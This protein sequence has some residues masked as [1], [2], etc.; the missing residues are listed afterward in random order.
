MKRLIISLAMLLIVGSKLFSQDLLKLTVKIKSPSAFSYSYDNKYLAVS[1]NSDVHLLNAGSDTKAT[2]ISDADDVSNIIFSTDN[3][4]MATSCADRTIKLWTIPT[5]KLSATLMGHTGAVIALRFLNN[6]KFI[7]S[8]GEDKAVNLWNIDSTKLVYS[9]KD[10]IKTLRALDVSLDDRWVATAGA[11][12]E[13]L[14]REALTG[15]VVKK[16]LAH[17]NWVRTL[18]F[19][20]DSK[21]LASGGDDKKIILW[22]VEAGKQIKEFPQRGWIY[23]LKFSNDGKYL[24]AALEKNSVAV[25]DLATGLPALKLEDFQTPVK[26]IA[27]SPNGK[28]LAT[29]EEFVPTVKYWNIESLH[30]SPVFRHKDSKDKS[31]PLIM[32]S[33]PPN[34]QDNRARIYKDMIDLRG[35]V[36]DESGV[37][38]LKVNGIV[39]PVKDNGNFVINM[40]LAMGDNFVNMEV[41]DVNDNISLKKLVITRKSADGEEYNP[42]AAK[43]YLL[44]IGINNYLHWPKLNNAV[45]DASDI[46]TVLMGKYNFEF[47]NVTLLQDDQATRSSIYKG[48]RS[49]IEKVSPHDNLVVYFSGH[50]YFDPLLNEGYW[51]PVDAEVNSSGD[52]ISNTEILKVLGSINSQHTFLVADACFSGALFA[53][54]RR[55]YTDNVEKFKSRW[56]LAS[57]RLET[58]SDGEMGNNSP[59]AKRVI[60]FLRENEKDKFA[61]SELIQY[62]KTQVAED[63]NQTPIGN[64]LKALGDEGGELVFYKKKGN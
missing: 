9:K 11:D 17:E 31:G 13:I 53:D 20:P 61:I 47:S 29:I 15:V 43:N 30:I 26:A 6:D 33:N 22:D 16:L 40:P 39:T 28:E 18:S 10:H 25:Y 41:T 34:I 14:L 46:A 27:I 44:V 50:G 45:K 52:Y 62:V 37:R 56:G 1:T 8:I 59:F 36:T 32:V 55:G 42:A 2:S 21:T 35:T 3:S 63:T 51:I 49:L 58:V 19:S 54:S 24:F 64:P 23:D 38:S 5:G 60:Q 48:L 7:I 4:L 57:G 12:R